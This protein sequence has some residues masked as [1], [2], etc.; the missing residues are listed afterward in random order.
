ML[1]YLI[2]KS[3]HLAA[4]YFY[5][6]ILSFGVVVYFIQDYNLSLDSCVKHVALLLLICVSIHV[7][8]LTVCLGYRCHPR[9]TSWL[10]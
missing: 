6:L 5:Q 7:I 8:F 2:K 10:D 1:L 4:L 9:L 3:V